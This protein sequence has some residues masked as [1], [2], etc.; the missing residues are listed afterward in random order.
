VRRSPGARRLRGSTDRN[1]EGGT[2]H[3]IA[4]ALAAAGLLAATPAAAGA[5]AEKAWV[6][7]YVT[8]MVDKA[9]SNLALAEPLHVVLPQNHEITLAHV[10]DE[11]AIVAVCAQD[12]GGEL[13]GGAFVTTADEF[14]VTDNEGGQV[15]T[16][17]LGFFISTVWLEGTAVTPGVYITTPD[18][19]PTSSQTR[20][21]G[22]VATT[23][24]GETFSFDPW[25]LIL[26]RPADECEIT[27]PM[28]FGTNGS[29]VVM[30]PYGDAPEP[31]PLDPDLVGAV[32]NG[33][34]QYWANRRY[35]WLE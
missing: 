34:V 21:V 24:G 10:G 9:E 2:W 28:T 27:I 3:G 23:Y 6:K 7:R 4:V 30:Y 16:D 14:M 22:R 33:E 1:G 25:T 35:P 15:L 29:D 18:A 11:L 20:L 32:D 31:M 26:S 5:N 13:W 8:R 12:G 17:A 19:P